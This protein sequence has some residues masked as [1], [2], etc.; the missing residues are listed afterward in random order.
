MHRGMIIMIVSMAN[1]EWG[2]F[3]KFDLIRVRFSR[4]KTRGYLTTTNLNCTGAKTW[5]FRPKP[6]IEP[7]KLSSSRVGDFTYFQGLRQ[8]PLHISTYL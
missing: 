5:K 7:A 8:V 4:D 1:C 3:L 2:H 6:R